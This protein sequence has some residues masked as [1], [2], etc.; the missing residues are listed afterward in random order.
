M[1]RIATPLHKKTAIRAV[2]KGEHDHH[3]K[4]KLLPLMDS[5]DQARIISISP[6]EARK[7]SGWEFTAGAMYFNHFEEL[8][9]PYF[10]LF[11]GFETA[12]Q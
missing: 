9:T 6:E 10:R 5:F 7:P 12:S 8:T 2:N 3:A 11:E 1:F 4:L